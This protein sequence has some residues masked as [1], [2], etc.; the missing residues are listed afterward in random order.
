MLGIFCL[1]NTAVSSGEWWENLSLGWDW[2]FHTHVFRLEIAGIHLRGGGEFGDGR[3]PSAYRCMDYMS[4]NRA[5]CPTEFIFRRFGAV[6]TKFTPL[7]GF[8]GRR[9]GQ[10]RPTF[11]SY[12]QRPYLWLAGLDNYKLR[13]KS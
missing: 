5:R 4:S 10:C 3:N 12:N 8:Q 9:S 13:R 11:Y 2:N 6:S 7:G 1:R